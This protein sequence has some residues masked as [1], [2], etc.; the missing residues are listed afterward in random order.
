[1]AKKSAV[2]GNEMVKALVKQYATK[3]ETLKA[4]AR[5]LVERKK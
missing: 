1:M 5:Y 2:N 3:R 4:I